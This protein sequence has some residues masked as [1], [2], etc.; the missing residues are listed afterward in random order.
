MTNY[1]E[2]SK[3]LKLISEDVGSAVTVL[4]NAS[5][6]LYERLEDLNWSGFYL[7]IGRAHV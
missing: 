7:K 6:L 3:E 5:A 1:S 4:S 2:L